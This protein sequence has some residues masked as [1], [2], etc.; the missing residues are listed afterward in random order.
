MDCESLDLMSSSSLPLVCL[1]QEEIIYRIAGNH[2]SHLLMGFKNPYQ[3]QYGRVCGSM[4][5]SGMLWQDSHSIR[6]RS[7]AA[8][9]RQIPR[10][11]EKTG[12]TALF[13]ERI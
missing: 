5:L 4:G 10:E 8:V 6:S 7:L 11:Q 2:L 3:E 13:E 1:L 12:M 9:K